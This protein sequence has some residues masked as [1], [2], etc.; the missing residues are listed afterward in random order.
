MENLT[1][2]RTY[3]FSDCYGGTA[4]DPLRD[5]DPDA[6]IST[7]F[8]STPHER[9]HREFDTL[10]CAGIE[11][12]ILRTI[13]FLHTEL[14]RVVGPQKLG[15]TGILINS[16]PRT[17]QGNN[18]EDFYVAELCDGAVRVVAPIEVLAAVKPHVTK[19]KRLPNVN[20]RLYGNAEQFRSSYTGRL[21]DP[22]HGIVLEDARCDEI[23]D[24]SQEWQ[25]AYVDRFGNVVTHSPTRQ[26]LLMQPD[27]AIKSVRL[28]IGDNVRHV[29]IGTSLAEAQSGELTAYGNVGNIDVV[30]KWRDKEN[31]A[32]RLAASAY[33]QFGRPSIGA[34]VSVVS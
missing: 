21:L 20:N 33:V 2:T 1:L 8:R 26:E 23:P 28:R 14:L 22:N 11:G 13:L 25:V 27:P 15:G 29:L 19:V 16:A 24:P 30:R 17:E 18:G 5:P 31:V 12:H 6:L 7:D 4:G 32:A 10:H 34:P 9:R 3:Y